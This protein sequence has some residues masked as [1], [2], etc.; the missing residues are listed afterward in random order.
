MSTIFSTVSGQF[1]KYLILGTL[2][3]VAI[4]AALGLMFGQA[5]TPTSLPLVQ[6][7]ETL[8][9]QWFTIAVI[10]LTVVMSG[11]LYNL[12]TP[13]IRLYEGYPWRGSRIGKWRVERIQ[14][15]LDEASQLRDRLKIALDIL[16]KN[17]ADPNVAA[18]LQLRRTRVS[19]LTRSGLPSRNQI[20]PTSLGNA[21]KSFEEYPFLQYGMDAVTLWPR[22]VAVASKEYLTGID[23]AKTSLNFFLNSSFLSAITSAVLLLVGL[24]FKRPFANDLTFTLW[25]LEVVGLAVASWLFYR[26]SVGRATAWG[27]LVKGTFDLYRWDLLKQLGYSQKPR[28]RQ[29]EREIW[30][31]ISQQIVY[32]DPPDS[33]PLPYEEAINDETVQVQTTPA[34]IQ[35]RIAY[36]MKKST[37][38]GDIN[39]ICQIT[40]LDSMKADGLV[41]RLKPKSGWDFVWGSA[42]L[43]RDRSTGSPIVSSNLQ[44][45]LGSLDPQ[46]EVVF[47]CKL[48]YIAVLKMEASH[49]TR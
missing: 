16:K 12:N 20:L 47:T 33:P 10:A 23:D 17:Q 9:K 3:P 29:L 46:R 19:V 18:Q 26:S 42:S 1:T 25:A 43:L 44:F 4:F 35:I 45:D 8:D 49:E 39:L 15:R 40:N 2:L 5:V 14:T 38:S 36:G 27:E 48:M 24:A 22:I 34:G 41:L 21:I 28:T 7:L 31:E 13:I 32:R 37:F 6:A 30:T 11:L